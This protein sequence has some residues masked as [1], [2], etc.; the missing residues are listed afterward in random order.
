MSKILKALFPLMIVLVLRAPCCLAIDAAAEEA[1]LK[2][3]WGFAY[4]ILSKRGNMANDPV[5]R[6]LMGHVCLATNRPKES[7]KWFNSI[8][9][10]YDYALWAERTGTL[11]ERHLYNPVAI[12]LSADAKLRT[13][14]IDEAIEGFKLALQ[15]NEDFELASIALQ[16]AYAL[17]G[18]YNQTISDYGQA[19]EESPMNARVYFE[20]GKAYNKKGDNDKAISDYTKALE[21]NPGHAESYYKRG[22]IHFQKGEYNQAISDFT[23]TVELD[24]KHYIAYKSR[25]AAYYNLR[26]YDRAISDYT[27]ALMIDPNYVKAYNNRGAAYDE[28]CDYNKAI[29]D[30]TKALKISPGY[31][32]A[33][34]NRAVAYFNKNEFKNAI[35]DY[36]KAIEIDPDYVEAYLGRGIIFM[37]KI[38]DFGKGCADWKRACELGKCI[39]YLA[40]KQRGDCQ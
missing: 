22:K 15:K 28:I 2:N 6:L 38:G 16:R 35:S 1:V 14:R 20:R 7:S 30:Y 4:K 17:K 8:V 33:Y 18:E 10:E 31:V 13:D 37:R 21:I 24:K 40:A 3:N 32:K 26:K 27:K 25:G 39:N 23:K 36:T 12:Y 5:S 19:L 34:N 11:L 29:T 9:K